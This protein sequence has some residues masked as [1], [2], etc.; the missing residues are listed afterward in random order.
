MSLIKK[1]FGRPASPTEAVSDSSFHESETTTEQGSRNAPRRELVQVVLRDTI[2]RHG[3]PSSWIDC[4]IL[5]VVTR[6][7]VA[8]MHVQ[9]IVRE[10]EDRLLA[11]VPAFQTSFMDE[12]ERYEPRANEWLLSLSW[13][14]PALRGV[15]PAMP[16]PEAWGGQPA[17]PPPAPALAAGIMAPSSG[18]VSV[19]S[20]EEDDLMADVQALFAIRDAAMRSEPPP[21]DEDTVDFEPTRPGAGTR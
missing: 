12:I 10:G 21:T 17:A 13:Q 16:D 20:T 8:G 14:F 18:P 2:R 3:I 5:S 15:N 4:R 1:F 6:S 9:L 11:F 19:S 7:A